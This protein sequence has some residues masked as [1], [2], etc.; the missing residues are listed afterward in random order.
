[1]DI[2]AAG[3]QNAGWPTQTEC[4][5]TTS[6]K[7]IPTT[8]SSEALATVQAF[9][10]QAR[11]PVAATSKAMHVVGGEA[12]VAQLAASI[13]ADLQRPLVRVPLFPHLGETEKHL[14]RV[15]ADAK[16]KGA[17]LLFDEADALFGKRG[18]VKDAHDRYANA[19][20][21]GVM[22]RIESHAGVAILA[23]RKKQDLDGAFTR[24]FATVTR[25]DL[26]D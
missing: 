2:G 12:A 15:F 20:A 11:A 17:V 19:A 7:A 18:D 21:D 26:P 5:M 13:A 9:V 1:M 4:D 14:D 8:L 25:V 6:G 10:A 16:K 23:T 3:S 24:R 22:Q